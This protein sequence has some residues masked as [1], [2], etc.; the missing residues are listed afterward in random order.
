MDENKREDSVER[1]ESSLSALEETKV[2][3]VRILNL[4]ETSPTKK[5][6]LRTELEFISD[7]IDDLNKEISNLKK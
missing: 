7:Q 2:E 3:K 1:L 5:N 6:E 4:E